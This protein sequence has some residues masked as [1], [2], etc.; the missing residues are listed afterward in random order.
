MIVSGLLFLLSLQLF[1]GIL[2]S[3]FQRVRQEMIHWT[4]LLAALWLG[5]CAG[6]FLIAILQAARSG[7]EEIPNEVPTLRTH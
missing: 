7:E 1:V 2:N 3:N 6:V 4:W 5:V